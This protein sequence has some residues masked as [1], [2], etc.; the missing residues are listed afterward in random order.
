[1]NCVM[2]SFGEKQTNK[3]FFYGPIKSLDKD[4]NFTIL[5]EFPKTKIVPKD[6]IN[7]EIGVVRWYN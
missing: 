5:P 4:L 2:I 6:Q 1:M 3:L 7:S